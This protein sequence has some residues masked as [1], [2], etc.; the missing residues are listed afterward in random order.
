MPDMPYFRSSPAARVTR[1]AALALVLVAGAVAGARSQAPPADLVVLNAR[2]VTLDAQSRIAEA[3]AIRD[4][5]FVAV[6]STAD[7]RPLVGSST[8][9]IDAG[10]DT[11]V[12]GL[13]DSHV[14]ALGVAGAEARQ[15]FVDLRSIDAIQA[16]VRDEAA[17]TPA[18]TWIW[19]PRVFPTRVRERR[20]PT[21]AELDA[22]APRNPV[23]VDGAYALMVNTAALEAAGISAETPNPPGGAI[24]KD[25]EG[26]P[27]G[28]L[29]NV[30]GLLS[31]FRPDT[32]GV[33][34]DMLE[35][36]HRK[37]LETGITSVVERG[38]NV[39]GY[40]AYR[41]LQD[42]S[43]LRVR[44]TVTIR[45]NSDG[46]VADTERFIRALPFR[47]GEGD[48]RL[49]V[50]PLKIVADGGILAG[51][52]YMRHPYG[53]N[54]SA[55]YGVADPGY[56]GFLTRT[57][58]ALNAIIR[59]GHRLGWQMSAHVTGD[60]GVDAVLD[61]VEAAHGD[62][63]IT[64]RRFTLIHAYFANADTARRAA[65]LGVIV[66]TQPAW[67]FKDADALAEALGSARLERFIGLD[68]W[69]DGGV[70]VAINTDH[71]FGLEP[72][73]SMNPY[74]PFLTMYVAVTR[75]TEG[76][77]VFGAGQAVSRE[78]A[79]RMMT[80]EAARL[81]F[82]EDRKGSIEVGK[83]GDLVVLSGDL[84][85]VPAEDIRHIRAKTTVVGGEIAYEH[86]QPRSQPS[87]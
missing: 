20:F 40:R 22:A 67:Y 19:S 57:P 58:E 37:Y 55:L 4:G 80:T 32:D 9:V 79:L 23:V 73:T 54:A 71:M 34:L 61:A 83:L 64:D 6:G 2:I 50:G 46:T 81:S 12:P 47:F 33:P 1:R 28:L 38:A 76:G 77:Q 60:A 7:V 26:R 39:E 21:R 69:L 62:A 45:V 75:R 14:H 78:Q 48:D 85:A 52:A 84:F 10:G 51:T 68:T 82:D 30:G 72:N 87:R 27:T 15:P 8:R 66:D 59:T 65:R 25:D 41:A 29:R 44:A 35:T 49:K 74:N 31:R 17:R 86:G 36:V 16:W 13:I 56:R 43:R 5:V 70:T 63:P 18:G 53:A 11:V 42:A 24:V 3:V